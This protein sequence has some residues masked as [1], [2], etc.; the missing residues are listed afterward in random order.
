[1]NWLRPVIGLVS[2]PTSAPRASAASQCMCLKRRFIAYRILRPA[3]RRSCNEMFGLDYVRSKQV[4]MPSPARPPKPDK[5]P[6]FEHP[7]VWIHESVAAKCFM[8][9]AKLPAAL[10][11]QRSVEHTSELQSQSNLV[12]R[13]LLEKKK[14]PITAPLYRSQCTPTSQRST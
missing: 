1:M 14:K 8:A 5:E 3:A 12:C 7:P 2:Q 11:R 9:A 4:P 10:A 6:V 13:L